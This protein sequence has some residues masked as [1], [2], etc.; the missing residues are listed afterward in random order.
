[1]TTLTLLQS[2]PTPPDS[3]QVV[4]WVW[5]VIIVLLGL[6]IALIILLSKKRED[7][8]VTNEKRAIAAESLVK[9]RD[10]E[11]ADCAKGKERLLTEVG[12]LESENKVLVGI[13]ISEL[14]KFWENKTQIE[15]EIETLKSQLRVTRATLKKWEDGGMK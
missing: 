7:V 12:D 11:L 3:P 14:M 5:W 1:M 13:K 9:V 15:E 8:Q 6:G 4:Q 2:V 10:T